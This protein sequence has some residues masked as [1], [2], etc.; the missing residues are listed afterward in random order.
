MKTQTKK[1]VWK[2]TEPR[3]Y[4]ADMIASSL[5][6]MGA[7][8]AGVAEYL[9]DFPED[10]APSVTSVSKYCDDKSGVLKGW[11][12]KE[13]S[14]AMYEHMGQPI[15]EA[16]I[17]YCKGA[18]GRIS[19][20]A[21]DYGTLAHEAVELLVAG[22]ALKP[23][24]TRVLVTTTSALGWREEAKPKPRFTELAVYSK[25]HKYAG[26]FDFVGELYGEESINDYKS[27]KGIYPEYEVQIQAYRQAYNEML[28]FCQLPHPA[29]KQENAY[30]TR[31]PKT[32]PE[33]GTELPF[34]VMQVKQDLFPV[35]E[36]AL[37]IF[38][39]NN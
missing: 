22:K 7:T 37:T 1:K 35:F 3:K 23:E 18:P 16:V 4:T 9:A 8:P 5:E 31:L 30:I 12:I 26:R 6:L 33:D 13:M 38:H 19:D 29:V 36:A 11:A 10:G 20:E 39:Y 32:E 34:E 25:K 2:G 15:T 21:K 28:Q 24:H 17:K 14:L 27:S